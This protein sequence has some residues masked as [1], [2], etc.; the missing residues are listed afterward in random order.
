MPLVDSHEISIYSLFSIYFLFESKILEE[1]RIIKNEMEKKRRK[2]F[3]RKV[4]N[5]K[6][7]DLILIQINAIEKEGR[8][9]RQIDD[10]NIFFIMKR[11][12]E[13]PRRN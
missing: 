7:E 4:E 6:I 13:N 3:K 9:I 1:K 5:A 8:K 12:S 11:F 2:L 10:L